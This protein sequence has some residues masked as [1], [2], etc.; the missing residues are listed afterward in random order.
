[1]QNI[2]PTLKIEDRSLKNLLDNYPE[3]RPVY[4]LKLF[5][6]LLVTFCLSYLTI[7]WA[8]IATQI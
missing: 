8:I 5:K 3:E 4:I 1:M 6:Y 2:L 7:I